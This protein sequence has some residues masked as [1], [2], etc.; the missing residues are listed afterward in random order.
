MWHN[1]ING[2][3]VWAMNSLTHAGPAGVMAFPTFDQ[4][5]IKVGARFTVWNAAAPCKAVAKEKKKKKKKRGRLLYP[6]QILRE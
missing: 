4:L 5:R 1:E 2:P 6:F 3:P